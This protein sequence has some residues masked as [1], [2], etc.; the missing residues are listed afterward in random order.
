M[1]TIS[2]AVAP[3]LTNGASLSI[4]ALRAEVAVR[5]TRSARMRALHFRPAR[6]GA[7]RGAERTALRRL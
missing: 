2:A 3:S 7:A 1:S 6:H 5:I 4:Y